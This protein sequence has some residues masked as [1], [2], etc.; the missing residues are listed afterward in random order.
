MND[1]PKLLTPGRIAAELNV[2]LH[3]VT[4]IL[5]TRN[6]IVP[7]AKAGTLRLYEVKAIF[8][9]HSELQRIAGRHQVRGG[10]DE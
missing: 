3:K 9:V 5:R 6:Y 1:I 7:T 10:K 2:P 4:Y 8:Q